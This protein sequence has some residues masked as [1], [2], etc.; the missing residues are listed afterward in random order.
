MIVTPKMRV[1]ICVKQKKSM[2][3]PNLFS[4]NTKKPSEELV[5]FVIISDAKL[6]T[7]LLELSTAGVQILDKSREL[8]YEGL[9]QCVE[10]TDKA[11]QQLD[12]RS[13]KISETIFAVNTS[14]VKN[15]EVIDGKKPLIK[16]LTDDLNL[17]PLGFI[18][19]SESLAQQKVNENSL[20]SGV[21]VVATKEEIVFT[22]VYQGKIKESEV[23]GSSAD[24][25]SDF[26][27]GIARI[28]KHTEKQGNYLPPKIL[29]ASFDLSNT[30]L[31]EYQQKVYDL[32]WKEES[33][34]IQTPTVELLSD[35]KLLTALSNEAGKNAAAHKGL[36][37]L[38][39]AAS[40]S[41]STRVN[42]PE[43]EQEEADLLDS[44]E[45]GFED[46]FEKRAHEEEEKS[47]EEETATSFGIPIKINTF[48]ETV[49]QEDDNLTAVDDDFMDTSDDIVLDKKEKKKIDWSHKKNIKWFAGIGF[50]LGL[51]FL[52]I[53]LVFGSA[54]FA[55]VQA[56]V[57]L[58]KEVISKD[59]KITL[60]TKAKETDVEKLVIVAGT[61][62]KKASDTSTIQ[63]TG[64][65]IVGENAKGKVSVYNKTDAEKTFNKGTELKFGDLVFTLDDDITIA[66]ASSKPGG[67]D[68][69]RTDVTV[70][71]AQ[72]GAESNL[73]KDAELTV[74]SYASNT[75][76][77]Y[78]IDQA[79]TGGSSREVRVVAQA[80]L[81]ELQVD[82]RK[83]L[84]EEINKEFESESG[85]GTYI[86]PSNS[87]V[88]ETAKFDAKLEEEAE[89]VTLDLEVEVEALTYSGGD[90]KPVAQEILSKELKENYE[91]ED[92]DPQILFS[93]T[94]TDLD[95]LETDAV[96]A[97][98]V[99]ISSYALP[100]LS[101]DTIKQTILGKQFN[102]ATQELASQ[103]EIKE[104]QFSVIPSFLSSFVK[105]VPATTE[106][107]TVT[108]VK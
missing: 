45:F 108:F 101:E 24:F 35:Q 53:G 107:I 10:Q 42:D 31:H 88:D 60:D 56:K 104:V 62:K 83:E 76:N 67:E 52:V 87:V 46:P 14:W 100:K 50:I 37:D 85:N 15:G 63:T 13:E 80:D 12:K 47:F 95:K 43:V 65:K 27:E 25:A 61:V 7:T 66:S 17:K 1:R 5:L 29:L 84:V 39:L 6:Q 57:T 79:F 105:K 54:L 91:L 103:K 77:A 21:L 98:E 58:N 89:S 2:D 99:N 22:L 16:K 68:Y 102:Q 90:L 71:A 32:D 59:I 92:V 96:V 11:L 8:E 73:E 74:A 70:T 40:L 69:G 55:N 18:D 64:I 26:T 94:Q 82:L 72:I 75:Y 33:P 9:A 36:T 97:I 23:V 49:S 4:S 48:K 93:P 44:Q 81:D 30:E 20:F 86:L 28:K 41:G 78:V 34:F 19:V 106:K 38:A 51:V 3:L